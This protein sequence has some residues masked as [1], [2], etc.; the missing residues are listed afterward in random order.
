MTPVKER[1]CIALR[2]NDASSI[3]RQFVIF[4]I[5]SKADIDWWLLGRAHGSGRGGARS[6]GC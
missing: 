1:L 4:A 5:T 2:P 6:R 3:S